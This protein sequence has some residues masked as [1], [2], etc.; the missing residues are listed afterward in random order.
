VLLDSLFVQ[1]IDL[2]RLGHSYSGRDLLGHLLE[3]GKGATGEEDLRP[4]ASEYA[5]TGAADRAAPSV[6][7][8]VLVL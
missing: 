8:G 6:D 2:R 3:R 4:F 1:S 7:Y 5:G